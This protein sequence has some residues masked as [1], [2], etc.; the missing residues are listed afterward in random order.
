MLQRI[1]PMWRQALGPFALIVL[2]WNTSGAFA[3]IIDVDRDGVDDVT[4]N[5]ASR[6]NPDQ[7]DS[8][9]DGIGDRCEDQDSDGVLD[10]DDNCPFVANREQRDE[11]LDGM[12]DACD[13]PVDSDADGVPDQIDNCPYTPNPDQADRDGDGAGDA[14]DNC[15]DEAN[16]D[17]LDSD[18]DGQGDVCEAPPPTLTGEVLLA[19][20]GKFSKVRCSE[21]F[22]FDVFGVATGP[23][24][25]TFQERGTMLAGDA[26]P[27]HAD[28]SIQSP[29]GFVHGQKDFLAGVSN[30]MKIPEDVD[31]Q[32][33][34]TWVVDFHFA[35]TYGA[36][37]ETSFGKFFDKGTSVVSGAFVW[38]ELLGQRT[39]KFN[40]TFVSGPIDTKKPAVLRLDPVIDTNEVG[41]KHS[42]TASVFT[43]TLTPVAKAEVRFVVTGSVTTKGECT[44]GTDGTCKFTYTGPMFP[45]ADNI[46]V[47]VDSDRDSVQDPDEPFSRAAKAWVF[48]V[49]TPGQVTGGGQTFNDLVVEGLT[50]GFNA[51]SDAL[52]TSGH[53]NVIDHAAG[54]HIRCLD[55]TNLVQVGKHATFFGNADINGVPTEYR[56]DVDDVAEPGHYRDTFVIQTR[57]GYA[58]GGLVTHGNVQVHPQK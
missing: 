2:L 39:L 38:N 6:F 30:C 34:T 36:T 27:F 42:I 48:P 50:F 28:F 15:S 40:E 58:G 57:S 11:D 18:G 47:Y 44:T 41:T 29:L 9:G 55:V 45:G 51:R 5:C 52:E 7:T 23:F 4:D 25:G 16:P 19:T 22:S 32:M 8:D 24:P 43:V 33:T 31:G 14:C 35:A 13:A 20:G 56:I 10:E 26:R 49:S 1:P 17:Q 21:V 54:I 3:Q 53:C 46:H 37:I 12:G